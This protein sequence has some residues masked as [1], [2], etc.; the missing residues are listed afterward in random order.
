MKAKYDSSKLVFF[1]LRCILWIILLLIVFEAAR[2]AYSYGRAIFMD[3][4][5]TESGAN[6]DVEV[7]VME[8]SSARKVGEQLEDAGV[9]ADKT[10]FFLQAVLSDKNDGVEGG[11]YLFNSSMKPSKI[12]DM[13][14]TG[15]EG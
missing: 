11:T 15:P 2:Y 10:L 8:G 13:L 12:L 1:L 5:F 3:E 7:F 4:A 6:E 9:I 14:Q